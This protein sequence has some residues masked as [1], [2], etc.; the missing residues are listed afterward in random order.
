MSGAIEV[1]IDLLCDGEDVMI[2][3]VM[4]HVEEAGVHSGDS[5]CVTPPHTL[6]APVVD[7]ICRAS[8]AIALELGVCGLMNAQFAVQRD[9]VFVIEVNP[10]ASRTV[11]FISK[12]TGVPLARLAARVM[13]GEKIRN[14]GV[15]APPIHRHEVPYVSV[16]AAVL[17]FIKFP[18]TDTLLGPEMRSTGEVMGIDKEYSGA[19]ARP[20]RGGPPVAYS[21]ALLSP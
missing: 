14:L 21:A 4:Q 18:G 1:D 15:E 16:K 17:P 13:A 3:G 2:G 11:P 10:R 12:A 8:K 9:R 6:S 20:A 19:F 7:E 5:S